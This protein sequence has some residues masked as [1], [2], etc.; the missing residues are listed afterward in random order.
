MTAEVVGNTMMAVSMA[1]IARA[2][3]MR[4]AHFPLRGGTG[5]S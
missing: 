2:G 4:L 1:Q 5:Y 3:G